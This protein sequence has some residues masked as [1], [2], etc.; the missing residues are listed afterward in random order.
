[1]LAQDCPSAPFAGLLKVTHRRSNVSRLRL[2]DRLARIGNSK[3]LD[4]EAKLL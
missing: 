4:I 2:H 1:M 3:D